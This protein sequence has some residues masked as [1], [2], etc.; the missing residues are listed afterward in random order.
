MCY[1][2]CEKN[3][4]KFYYYVYRMIIK[5]GANTFS[6]NGNNATRIK[7][8]LIKASNFCCAY[9][10]SFSSKFLTSTSKFVGKLKSNELILILHTRLTRSECP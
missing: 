10:I 1:I 5:C 3:N 6:F 2:V 4:Y 7:C 9:C 8:T